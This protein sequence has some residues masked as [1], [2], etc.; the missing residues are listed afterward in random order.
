MLVKFGQVYVIDVVGVF[1]QS[2]NKICFVQSR[3]R[4]SPHC[5][6]LHVQKSADLCESENKKRMILFWEK[7]LVCLPCNWHQAFQKHI[8][9]PSISKKTK[10]FQQRSFTRFRIC[11]TNL[12]ERGN[13]FNCVAFFHAS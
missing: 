9:N 8:R 10:C 7:L 2:N 11:Q 5:S 6:V 1:V 13:I 4:L 3:P 12:S